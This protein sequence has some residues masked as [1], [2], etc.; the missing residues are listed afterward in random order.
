M[1][2]DD[3]RTVKLI[4]ARASAFVDGLA[5]HPRSDSPGVLEG[6]FVDN[7]NLILSD[8]IETLPDAKRHLPAPV[9]VEN[10]GSGN[11]RDM[12]SALSISEIGVYALQVINICDVY[13]QE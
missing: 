12:R 10:Y 11:Y 5:E 13:L 4:R 6:T 3:V 8:L 1:N 9:A 7:F 2:A